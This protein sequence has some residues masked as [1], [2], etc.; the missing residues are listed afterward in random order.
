MDAKNKRLDIEESLKEAG[1]KFL[2]KEKSL[3][4]QGRPKLKIINPLSLAK[5][6]YEKGI[7]DAAMIQKLIY[8]THLEILEKEN[9]LI[10]FMDGWKAWLG[11]PVLEETFFTMTK[12][13][14]KH[15]NYKKLFSQVI[16]LEEEQKSK[17][18]DIVKYCNF[19]EEYYFDCEKK[20]SQYK[21]AEES[22]NQPWE[23]AR[24]RAKDWLENKEIETSDIINFAGQKK[25]QKIL[26]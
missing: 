21:I 7:E 17:D 22:Q 10:H 4:K 16:P 23:L 9:V 24:N 14:D 18:V 26:V 13:W 8:L 15:G 2:K 6:F 11:G 20:K 3:I 25:Q 19:W 12:E 1:K 5:Y